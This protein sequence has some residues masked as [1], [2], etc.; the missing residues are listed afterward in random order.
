MATYLVVENGT[1][2][3]AIEWDGVTP[4]D[5]GQGAT[6]FLA[7]TDGTWVGWTT[8]DGGKTFQPPPEPPAPDLTETEQLAVTLVQAGV[9]TSDQAVAAVP[10]AADAINAAAIVAQPADPAQPVQAQV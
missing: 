8:A 2:T 1:V 7:G 3:N 9:L 10:T 6:L 5:P 4:Y